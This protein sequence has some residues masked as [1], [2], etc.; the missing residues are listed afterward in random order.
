MAIK[1]ETKEIKPIE[2]DIND[3]ALIEGTGLD[4]DLTEDWQAQAAPP[5]ASR[6]KLKLTIEDDKFTVGVKQGFGKDDPNGKYYKKQLA[7]KIQAEGSEWN[8]SIVFY[9]CNTSIGR[10][11]KLSTMAGLL[12]MLGAKLPANISELKLARHF[13]AVIK[14]N[15]PEL[16][17]DC[18]WSAWDMEAESK[19]DFGA[20][21]KVGM[22][23]FPLVNGKRV[24]IIEGAKG[25]Q[26]VAK[27]KI[28]KFLG[29][30]GSA[31]SASVVSQP[32]PVAVKAE[33]KPAEMDLSGGVDM[34]GD[35][36]VL[37]DLS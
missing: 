3:T 14:K 16:I 34:D 11:K 26:I 7:C 6:Y 19:G 37:L 2:I 27:L 23:N 33:A 24:H 8:N 36:E 31:A 1:D 10:G 30:P 28:T 15:E 4:L 20:A 12:I 22:K 32:K 21:A 9:N 18:D 17:A 5:P 13:N 29:K 35:G 25:Q